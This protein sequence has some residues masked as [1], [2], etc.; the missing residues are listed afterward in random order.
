LPVFV[1]GRRLGLVPIVIALAISLA[2]CSGSSESPQKLPPLSTTPAAAAS[3]PSTRDPKAAAVAV[4]REYFRLLNAKTTLDTAKSLRALMV[5]SCSCTKVAD[6]TAAVARRG[7]HYFGR[8]TPRSITP[9][10]S[11][12]TAAEVLVDY[13]YTATGIA[14]S[15]GSVVSKSPARIGATLDV[16]LERVKGVWLIDALI[17]VRKGHST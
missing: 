13:D 4:V 2:G 1:G 10:L 11:G 12:P 5:Q 15:D 3:T 16:R 14:R 6:S 17:Y 8:T 7:E 9:T